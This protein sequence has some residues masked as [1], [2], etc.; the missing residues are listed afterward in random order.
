MAFLRLLFMDIKEGFRHNRYFYTTACL[1]FLL[2]LLWMRS[3]LLEGIRQGVIHDGATYTDAVLYLLRGT[4]R[5]Y[6]ERGDNY[7]LPVIWLVNQALLLSLTGG[8]PYQNA[9]TYGLQIFL[10]LKKKTHWWFSKCLWCLVTVTSFYLLCYMTAAVWCLLFQLPFRT[11]VSAELAAA[12]YG[13]DFEKIT[14]RTLWPLMTVLPCAVSAAT[15]LLQLF[16]GL[17]LG[18]QLAF[19]LTMGLHVASTVLCLPGLPGNYCMILRSAEITADGLR[20]EWGLC[21]AGGIAILSILLGGVLVSRKD[22]LP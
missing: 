20:T 8:Y 2:G 17:V 14:G 3:S 16:L 19:L 11:S 1:V 13:L 10:R 12:W 4:K 22:L 9:R 18:P 6:P 15:A 7:H 5:F 21:L